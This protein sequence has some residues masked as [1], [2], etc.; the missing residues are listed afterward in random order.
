M[1]LKVIRVRPLLE[2]L[3]TCALVPRNSYRPVCQEVSWPLHLVL[4][5]PACRPVPSNVS[6]PLN[7]LV[8]REVSWPWPGGLTV[9]SPMVLPSVSAFF[10]G[11]VS[12][13]VLFSASPFT[14]ASVLQVPL[15]QSV[16]ECLVIVC[17][18]SPLLSCQPSDRK[19]RKTPHRL[20]C[21]QL[22]ASVFS[23]PSV[24]ASV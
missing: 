9:T 8:C 12:A 10:S 5:Q 3:P 4:F 13:S 22:F 15:P 23:S 20:V 11:G 2:S 18:P 24:P 21:R 19:V 7:G 14:L 1:C 17:R 16:L 6:R